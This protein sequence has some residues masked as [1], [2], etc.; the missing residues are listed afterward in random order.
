MLRP[1]A[2]LSRKTNTRGLANHWKLPP[3]SLVLP[4][5]SLIY[6]LFTEHQPPP[7]PASVSHCSQPQTL[8][9]L[10]EF[11]LK[12]ENTCWERPGSHRGFCPP[13][14]RIL[15]QDH[16]SCP[17][18]HTAPAH[19]QDMSPLSTAR[20]QLQR[21]SKGQHPSPSSSIHP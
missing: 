16:Y 15:T 10:T 1:G 11:H 8:W 12:P 4:S 7:L 5:P 20:S 18:Q 2:D 13:Q 19:S 9:H 3:L 21:E 14:A 6:L 17:P